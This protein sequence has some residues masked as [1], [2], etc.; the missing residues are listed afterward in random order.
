MK[1]PSQLGA[2][3]G[4]PQGRTPSAISFDHSNACMPTKVAPKAA[5][6]Q[7]NKNVL[8]CLLIAKIDCERHGAGTRD[9]HKRHDRDENQRDRVTAKDRAKISLCGGH[10]SVVVTR[11]FRYPIRKQEKIKVSEPGIS[12]SWPFPRAHDTPVGR[13]PV[14]DHPVMPSG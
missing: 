13:R 12:T 10:G 7:I 1:K 3:N 5:V 4:L 8:L 2:P 6:M 14:I 11:T 9:Q